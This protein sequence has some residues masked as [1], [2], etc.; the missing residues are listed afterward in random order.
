MR[1]RLILGTVQLG[2]AYGIANTSGKP[3][4]QEANALVHAALDGGIVFFDTAQGYGD[5]EAVLGIA[6][7]ECGA[8]ASAR[9]IT[10]LAPALPVDATALRGS[11][12]RSLAALGVPK[13]YCL[14][15]HREEQLPLLDQ[16]QGT[17]MEDLLERGVTKHLGISVYTPE[18]ALRALAHRLVSVVQIPSSIFDRRFKMAGVF[19][20]AR[21]A[22]KELHIRSVFLQGVLGMTPE[23]LPAALSGLAPALTALRKT[24]AS[25]GCS[26]L[27]AALGYMLGES[28]VSVLFGAEQKA[29]V[30]Q[31]LDFARGCASLPHTL[32]EEMNAIFPPQLPELLNP[33]LWR[34]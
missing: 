15:L 7:R 4:Q 25:Y 30:R 9:I 11:V 19:E 1:E 10:K 16:W 5:S 26:P 6:L 21:E 28:R 29:Q 22:G 24:C 34:R 17:I 27:Q 20:A 8:A 12:T 13:L 31:N 2:Q 32:W 14:M 23:Q 3:A 18:A 33:A